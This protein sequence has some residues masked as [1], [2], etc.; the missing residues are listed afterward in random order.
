MTM[1]SLM[2]L[3]LPKD[4]PRKRRVGKASS[5]ISLDFLLQSVS[6]T[7]VHII[8]LNND[9]YIQIFKCI[10]PIVVITLNFIIWIVETSLGSNGLFKK[11]G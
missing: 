3:P 6:L 4:P 9:T 8:T 7:C 2:D 10:L 11:K 5:D 1:P